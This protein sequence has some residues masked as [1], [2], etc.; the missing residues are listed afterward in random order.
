MEG[1]A[2]MHAHVRYVCQKVF[3]KTRREEDGERDEIPSDRLA[4]A[5]PV[6]RELDVKHTYQACG[7]MA[8]TS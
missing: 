7:D 6:V 3:G 8:A 2:I 1:V 4:T 5:L